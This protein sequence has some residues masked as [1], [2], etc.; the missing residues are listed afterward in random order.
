MWSNERGGEGR[1]SRRSFHGLASW[2]L[3][4]KGPGNEGVDG[5]AVLTEDKEEV[6]VVS[7]VTKDT[8]EAE[9]NQKALW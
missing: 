2:R 7:Y 1:T 5:H 4:E 9:E 6:K 8:K 3:L